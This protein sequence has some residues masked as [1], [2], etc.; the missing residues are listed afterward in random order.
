VFL[1]VLLALNVCFCFVDA[2]APF[3][4]S[5]TYRFFLLLTAK[6]SFAFVY[7]TTSVRLAKL[8]AETS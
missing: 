8:P 1:E 7:G 5:S 3:F 4:L 2:S 6:T